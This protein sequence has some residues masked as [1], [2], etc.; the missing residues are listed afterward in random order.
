MIVT[1]SDIQR[2][3]NV[4]TG[5]ITTLT[6]RNLENLIVDPVLLCRMLI[7]IVV[8]LFAVCAF[9]ALLVVVVALS[10]MAVVVA[11][12]VDLDIE[13]AQFGIVLKDIEKMDGIASMIQLAVD[14][15]HHTGSST[16]A[17]N[18]RLG[19]ILFVVTAGSKNKDENE[20]S[21]TAPM[22]IHKGKDSERRQ[23]RIGAIIIRIHTKNPLKLLLMIGG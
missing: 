10:T 12:V 1:L 4:N 20:G 2:N 22:A 5:L 15:I 17:Q 9:T 13:A 7:G 23:H 3:G 8:V 16:H 21:D 11:V 18:G 14:R 6:G 19:C